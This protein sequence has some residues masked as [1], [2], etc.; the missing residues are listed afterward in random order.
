[1]SIQNIPANVSGLNMRTLTNSNFTDLDGRATT[2]LADIV[3]LTAGKAPKIVAYPE[4]FGAVGNGTTDD[5]VALQAC[6]DSLVATH[7]TMQL[8]AAVYKVSSVLTV[9]NQVSIDGLGNQASIIKTTATTGHIISLVGTDPNCSGAGCIFWCSF[10]NFQVTRT[11]QATV[12]DGFHLNNTCYIS[13]FQVYSFNSVNGFYLSGCGNTHLTSVYGGWSTATTVTRNGI[14]IDSSVHSNASTI[15]DGH[16]VSNG[17]AANGTGLLVS[18][19][20][21]A[22]LFVY[23]FET[24]SLDYGVHIVSTLGSSTT[25]NTCNSDLHLSKLIMD[26]IQKTGVWVQNVNGGGLPCVQVSDSHFESSATSALGFEID[27]S[28]GVIVSNCQFNIRGGSSSVGVYVTESSNCIIN[29]NV[30][31]DCPHPMFV[32]N[33][34]LDSITGNVMTAATDNPGLTHV[35]LVGTSS[36]N[37]LTA[38]VLSGFATTGLSFASG[39]NNN[40]AWPNI[41]DSANINT[42]ISDSGSGNI[43][44]N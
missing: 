37:I 44:T 20:C 4:D 32:N 22:D 43:T 13:F 7:G 6:I 28:M 36:L 33:S 17:G 35:A 42:P 8:S 10:R 5:T 14:F 1:M 27:T 41:I 24:A 11:A 26:T 31:E 3:A 25:L 40:I 12:G 38:N 34:N 30:F 9:P 19:A 29:G 16:C 2:Q 18:G 39:C 15:I 21:I 23:G